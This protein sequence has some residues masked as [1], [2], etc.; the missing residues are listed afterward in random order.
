MDGGMAAP[1]VQVCLPKPVSVSRFGETWVRSPTRF[2][3]HGCVCPRV[4]R[5]ALEYLGQLELGRVHLEVGEVIDQPPA[6]D[7]DE[8]YSLVSTPEAE[9]S[10]NA[11]SSW[12]AL[13][14]VATLYQLAS[15]NALTENF[16]VHDEPRFSWRGVLLDV[17]RHFISIAALQSIIDGMS[18]LKLNVLHLHL[19]DDQGFR[20]PSTAYPSLA[21]EEHYELESLIDLV[22]YGADRGVRIVPELDVPGHVTSWLVAHPEWGSKKI[23]ETPKYGVHKATLDVSSEAVLAAIATVFGELT[24]VFP[25]QYVHLGGD[26]VHPEWWQQDPKM[27]AYMQTHGLADIAAVQSEFTR[28]LVES[29]A[30]RGRRAIGWDEVLN[31][32]TPALT[33]QNW[34][35]ATTRDQA[36][37][38]GLDCI[39]SAPYYLDLHYSAEMHYA[40]DPA[41]TEISQVELED[42]QQADSRLA[43]VAQGIEWTRQWRRSRVASVGVARGRVLGGEACLWSELVNESV[44]H[45]RLFSRLP[46]VA[47]RLWSEAQVRDTEDFYQRLDMCLAMKPF[48]LIEVEQAALAA[49]G[50]D[51][52]QIEHV[53]LLEPVKW[54]GR[55][56]GHQALQARI[57]GHEMPQARPYDTTTAL[58]RVVDV[59]SPESLSARRLK[60]VSWDDWLARAEKWAAIAI[61]DYPP[62]TQDAMGAL[63]SLGQG[64]LIDG[65]Q[66]DKA[67]IDQ[68][69]GPHQGETLLAVVPWLLQWLAEHDR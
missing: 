27:Q 45:V 62:D 63:V 14:G 26:E 35:G 12:G 42:A 55:L 4:A 50:L 2:E 7:D 51:A 11:A 66:L 49:L 22:R 59:I 28:H 52:R 41:D 65:Q 1:V 18:V 16:T 24:E 56:L 25:D 67:K 20:F 54:Y 31:D 10:L 39:V 8:S 33:V 6:L 38:Q 13:R 47:E 37:D 19:S 58:D 3:W 68:C 57:E 64:L 43:H 21:S 32:Q 48:S 17:A 23:S 9:I 40:Y 30:Q 44:L 61:S 36:L 34:R 60:N 5:Y 46:A 15:S 29:L 69:Y 53:C